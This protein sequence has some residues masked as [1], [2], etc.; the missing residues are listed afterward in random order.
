MHFSAGEVERITGVSAS[1]QRH[2][3][4]RGLMPPLPDMRNARY[5]IKE[6]AEMMIMAEF[7]ESG[8]SVKT[9]RKA[10]ERAAA[11]VIAQIDG[12]TPRDPVL[13]ISPTA[14]I[15]VSVD[16]ANFATRL[17]ADQST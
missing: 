14:T 15:K 10:I 11:L 17:L 5:S 3:R 1:L 8:I 6:V 12:I 2:W 16:T 4:K 9:H 7:S 13:T